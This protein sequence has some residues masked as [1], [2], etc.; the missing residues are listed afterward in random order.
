MCIITIKPAICIEQPNI[1]NSSSPLINWMCRP[2][3]ISP[4]SLGAAKVYCIKNVFV[5]IHWINDTTSSSLRKACHGSSK[6]FKIWWIKLP[7]ILTHCWGRLSVKSNKI[8]SVQTY[9]F[10]SFRWTMTYVQ[11]PNWKP[12]PYDLDLRLRLFDRFL[13]VSVPFTP[14]FSHFRSPLLRQLDSKV[15]TLLTM[16]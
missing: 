12:R 8:H 2:N 9:G 14:S 5:T 10:H 1:F 6:H 16:A 7:S 13:D 11:V 3:S 4:W 15:L